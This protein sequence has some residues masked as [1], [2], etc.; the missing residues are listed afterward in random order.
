M[1]DIRVLLNG[2][3]IRNVL[4]ADSDKGIIITQGQPVAHDGPINQQ[5]GFVET[6]G[7]VEIIEN[8]TER[9]L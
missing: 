6:H 4:T 7:V 1:L 8:V 5:A 2:V 3:V 9:R